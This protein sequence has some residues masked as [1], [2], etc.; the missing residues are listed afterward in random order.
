MTEHSATLNGTVNANNASTT[1]TFQY[2]LTTAY[3]ST[4]TADQSPVTGTSD[5]A[6]SKGITGLSENTTYHYR[7]V[8]VNSVG[9]TNGEDMTFTTSSRI[10]T[11]IT[12]AA[13]GVTDTGATLNGIVN[14][15]G[16]STTYYF[17]W[18]PSTAYENTTPSQSAGSDT[19]DVVVS[20]NL[21]GL[22]L[23]IT[24]HYRLVATNSA[25]TGYGS[26]MIIKKSYALPFLQLLLLD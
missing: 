15:K 20:A 5:T 16:L 11:A 22:T 23:N 10:P 7:A 13:S 24:Y 12:S 3:G 1:V 18:G 19:S 6:V 9:T 17:E 21:T 8:G 4:V 25:G 26:D 2:G 14:P